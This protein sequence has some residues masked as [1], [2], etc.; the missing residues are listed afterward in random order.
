M[1]TNYASYNY[2]F[3]TMLRQTNLLIQIH[4]LSMIFNHS[5]IKLVDERYSLDCILDEDGME[6][7]NV[8][9][10]SISF[11]IA[12]WTLVDL[13]LQN[14]LLYSNLFLFLQARAKSILQYCFNS[15]KHKLAR[16]LGYFDLY[17]IDFMIDEDMKV[18]SVWRVTN[19]G[20]FI[21][22][23]YHTQV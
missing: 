19:R 15:V 17:G 14:L 8:P 3:V 13:G 1:T 2:I 5:I 11:K 9:T 21:W 23:R 10:L 7:I 22:A 4:Q 16:R 18:R 6:K 12:V 20:Y